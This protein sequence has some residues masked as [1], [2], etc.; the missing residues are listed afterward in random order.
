MAAQSSRFSFFALCILLTYALPAFSNDTAY[1]KS[2]LKFKQSLTNTTM[3][4][5]WKEPVTNNLCSWNTPNWTGCLCL[6]G[7]FVGLRLESMG[8]GG[9]IDID[10]IS[11]LPIFSL[12][13]MHNQFS[14]PFP[15]GINKLV[16][17]RSLYLANNSFDGEIADNAFSGMKV[18]RKVVL[19]Y[20]LFTGNIPNSLLELPK[21]VDLEIQNNQF[22]GR[23][24]DFWQE[25]LT[26]DFSYNKLQGP[27]PV[28]LANQNASSFYGKTSFKRVHLLSILLFFS[29]L[30]NQSESR[31]ITKS[32][33]CFFYGSGN[34]KLCGKPLDSC[35]PKKPISKTI[36]IIASVIGF[37]LAAFII[38]LLFC[39]LRAKPLKYEKSINKHQTEEPN[40]TKNEPTKYKNSEH[41]KL[42]FVK[43]DRERFE[44]EE[45][46]RAS[47]EVLGSGSFGSSYKAVLFSGQAYVVRRF[48]QMSNVGKEEFYEHMRRLGR[49][50][51]PNLLPLVAFYYRKEEKLLITDYVQNGS[52]A[53]HLHGKRSSNQPGLDW[54][55]RLRIVKGV[56]KGLAY[57]YKE[58]PSITL[59]HGHLKSS[60]VLLNS[61]YE[62]ILSEF[63]LIPVINKDHA[64]EFMAAYKSP[65]STQNE[66]L[67][68]KTDVWSLGILILE[69][70][71]GQFPANYLKQGKG[72]SADLATWVNS[73]VR[74]E[75]TGEVF[76]KDMNLGGRNG[77]G[78]MLRLLKIGMCCCEWN[79]EK[80]W[81][82]KEAVEKIEELK[83]RD[84]DD[85]Y[86]SYAS[87]GDM[88]SSRAMTEDDFSFSKN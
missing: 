43:N 1:A 70:L 13:V 30:I 60:N 72:P 63:A 32:S 5:N 71:T 34:T 26:V 35:K 81:D 74:E 18:M 22:Q 75:W 49:L 52:L 7:S 82:L 87:E 51:H 2:L 64:Q 9:V 24:P 37:A 40:Y 79:V 4:E 41:G 38:L 66:R 56:A 67:T 54:P 21:L 65:E 69:L 77:E 68:R 80:R 46:L 53:S 50:S 25:N 59:P 17:L 58:I 57:L 16:K 31:K 15:K 14:G 62:P 10:S 3:L 42:Y 45:L 73:V 47:A 85:D 55:T 88:Y 36:F 27:I 6:N 19:G 48:R 28:T 11:E 78:Q 33:I 12:S 20:N 8:L 76:D 84:S 83:E 44:L 39:R 61:K 23:I 29:F 86:S